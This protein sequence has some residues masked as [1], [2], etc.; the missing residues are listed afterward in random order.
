MTTSCTSSL[1]DRHVLWLLFLPVMPSYQSLIVLLF[2]RRVVAVRAFPRSAP[3]IFPDIYRQC[4]R[5]K[6]PP[7][8]PGA[9]GLEPLKAAYG[10]AD[11]AP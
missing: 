1:S 8:E 9:L 7:A 6:Y 4:I 5:G 11:A 2:F 3:C 10:A